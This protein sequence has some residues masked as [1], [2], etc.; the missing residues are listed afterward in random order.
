MATGNSAAHPQGPDGA[1]SSGYETDLVGEM[2][3][4][5]Y[6]ALVRFCLRRGADAHLAEDVAQETFVQA[7]RYLHH[8][9]P[10]RP[11]WPWLSTIAAR[12]AQRETT[13]A[14]RESPRDV[15]GEVDEQ[16]LT[17]IDPSDSDDA[18]V[19]QT[20]MAAVPSRQ[21]L[22]L[23]LRYEHDYTGAEAARFLGIDDNAFDQLLWR[24]RRRLAVEFSRAVSKE[25][26]GTS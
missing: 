1:P 3:Y 7:M 13:K 18:V 2:Y 22:A 21:R 17:P 11:M 8:Y 19:L 12:I 4:R 9:D 15:P 23:M 5:Y 25:R 20:A 6:R 16:A 14:R 10:E 26:R 24:A